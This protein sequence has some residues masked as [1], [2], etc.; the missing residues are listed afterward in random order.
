MSGGRPRVQDERLYLR[1]QA[2]VVPT[3]AVARAA[4]LRWGVGRLESLVSAETLLAWR[5]GW[6]VYSQAI[7]LMEADV[8]E[9][10]APKIA[11]A[12][13]A[14]EAEAAA[15]GH[16]PLSPEA[17]ETPL[18]GGRVLVVVRSAAEAHAVGQRQDGRERVVWSMEE[19][20]CVLPQLE[21]I[22]AAKLAWPGARVQPMTRRGESWAHDW[23][24]DDMP[25]LHDVA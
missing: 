4:E 16:A 21:Q 15:R 24:T 2:A 1:T 19:L 17:W 22:T 6:R 11:Q 8:V 7:T 23:A 10:V 12:I 18:E 5:E 9:R 3:D 20:A 25:E 13:V 14:M